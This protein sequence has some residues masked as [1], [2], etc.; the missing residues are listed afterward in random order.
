M[1]YS[2]APGTPIV[3]KPLLEALRQLIRRASSNVII[4]SCEFT[5]Q[6]DFILN[7]EITRQL[8]R[9][10][11]VRVYGN[12]IEQMTDM[13]DVYGDLGLRAFHWVPPRKKSLFH[14]KAITVDANWLYIGSANLSYNALNNSAEWGFIAHSP[15]ICKDLNDYV[16]KL[17]STGRFVEM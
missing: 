10:R 14:I 7:E 2:Q 9:N 8:K 6:Q 4:C 12:H 13:K 5:S 17:H 3:G 15:E 16:Q 11:V 1:F